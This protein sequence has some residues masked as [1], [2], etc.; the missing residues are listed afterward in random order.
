[1]CIWIL[2]IYY[3]I[4]GTKFRLCILTNL[5]SFWYTKPLHIKCAAL[6]NFCVVSGGFLMRGDKPENKTRI[7]G[8]WI[9]KTFFLE[10]VKR[11]IL[12]NIPQFLN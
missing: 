1:M 4:V 3:G 8:S 11:N 10:R 7:L 12:I 2:S 6:T 9:L 5:F